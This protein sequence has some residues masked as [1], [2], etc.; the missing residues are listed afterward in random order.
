M[1]EVQRACVWRMSW[2]L[3]I[4][5]ELLPNDAQVFDVPL[6]HGGTF[7]VRPGSCSLTPIFMSIALATWPFPEHC[8]KWQSFQHSLWE[9]LYLPPLSFC[10]FI[11]HFTVVCR[12]LARSPLKVA[13]KL[14]HQFVS[15]VVSSGR[16]IPATVHRRDT[17][18]APYIKDNIRST[19]VLLRFKIQQPFTQNK[20]Y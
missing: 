17:P 3:G 16:A 8:Y 13:L 15:R 14:H 10:K 1:C 9:N 4:T 2:I 11:D 12:K 6:F 20:C 18:S 19:L 7:S 5:I